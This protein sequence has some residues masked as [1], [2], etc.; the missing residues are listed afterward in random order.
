MLRKLVESEL[1]RK[2]Y[3]HRHAYI[4][5]LSSQ[6]IVYKGQLMPSQAR[7]CAPLEFLLVCNACIPSRVWDSGEEKGVG[8]QT[9][10]GML[11][12]QRVQAQQWLCRAELLH[13]APNRELAKAGLSGH[14]TVMAGHNVCKQHCSTKPAG[15]RVCYS[16]QSKPDRVRCWVA[17]ALV[18]PGPAGAG[19][20]VVHVPGALALQHQHVPVLGPR[21]AHALAG[22][23]RCARA[24]PLRWLTA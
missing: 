24:C 13:A 19:L 12:V 6:T 23:Q 1:L 2:G 15:G 10:P 14:C 18:L 8:C 3:N 16:S 20:H 9:L 5:S 21:A 7:C 22:P 17:G 4:A 11:L